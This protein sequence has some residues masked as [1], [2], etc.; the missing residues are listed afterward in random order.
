MSTVFPSIGPG[1]FVSLCSLLLSIDYWLNGFSL[2]HLPS[3]HCGTRHFWIMTLLFW[4]GPYHLSLKNSLPVILFFLLLCP[5]LHSNSVFFSL[6]Y[7]VCLFRP[8][9]SPLF[10]L[11]NLICYCADIHTSTAISCPLLSPIVHYLSEAAVE[12]SHI[13]ATFA[14]VP[15]LLQRRQFLLSFSIKY[16][17]V[18]FVSPF[19]EELKSY[20]ISPLIRSPLNI[21]LPFNFVG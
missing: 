20:S 21:C 7:R 9:P 19:V 1:H 18:C 10:F 11:F 6:L 12:I 14:A 16:S 15:F 5:Y 3:L 4:W 2:Q 13:F 8:L 17:P